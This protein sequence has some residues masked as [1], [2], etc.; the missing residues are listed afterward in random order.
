MQYTGLF[1]NRA[2]ESRSCGCEVRLLRDTV[3]RCCSSSTGACSREVVWIFCVCWGWLYTR[4]V[5]R[6]RN[7]SQ[8][9]LCVHHA[10]CSL[11]QALNECSTLAALVLCCTDCFW[12]GLSEQGFDRAVVGIAQIQLLPSLQ[13]I[14]VQPNDESQ[15]Q[16]AQPCS[17][18]RNHLHNRKTAVCSG[19]V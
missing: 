10:L 5:A 17:H 13:P 14:Q 8:C 11:N 1:C 19:S 12:T 3:L 4:N 15:R 7:E 18:C 6:I 16:N 9:W 2:A